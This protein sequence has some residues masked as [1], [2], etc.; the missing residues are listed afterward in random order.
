[1][2]TRSRLVLTLALVAL[3][4][5]FPS[6]PTQ[7]T[8]VETPRRGLTEV[9][10][11]NLGNTGFNTMAW[12]WVRGDKLYVGLGTW[13]TIPIF[14]GPPEGDL[15]PSETDNPAAPTKSGVK[16]LDATDPANPQLIKRIATVPGSQNNETRVLTEVST[17]SFTGDL[18][19]HSLEP[20]GGIGLISQFQDPSFQVPLAQ[21]GFQLYNV[22]DPANPVKLGTYNNGGIGTHNLYFVVR[23]D[24]GPTQR[25]FVLAVFN[26]VSDVPGGVRGELQIVEVTNPNSPTLIA[27][28]D[29]ATPQPDLP[30]RTRGTINYCVLHDVWPSDD[31]KTAYLSYWD[32]GTVL[33]DIANPATPQLIGQGLDQIYQTTGSYGVIDEGSTHA[34]MP[35][36]HWDGRRMI[37][38][39]DEDFYGGAGV[40][41]RV[42]SPANLA[43]FSV[44]DQWGGTAPVTGQTGNLVYASGGCTIADY[45]PLIAAGTIQ[46]NIAFLDEA[47]GI[48]QPGCDPYRFEQK[49]SAAEAA[50]AIGLV[51]VDTNDIP[52]GGAV[53]FSTIPAMEISHTAGVPI[54]DAVRGGTPV[55]ATLCRCGDNIDPWGFMRVIDVTDPDPANWRQVSTYEP[56]HVRDPIPDLEKDVFTAHHPMHGPDDR[57]YLSSYTTGVRV[58]EPTHEPG[59]FEEV[60]WFVP[61]PSDHPN[62]NDTDPHGALED[63]I[64]FWGSVPVI[65]PV[66]GQ[67]LIFNNDVNRGLYILAYETDLSVIKTD[68][69][70][71]APTGQTLTYTL[72]VTNEGPGLAAAVTVTDTLPASVTLLSADPSQGSCSGSALVSC[73]LGSIASGTSVTVS[74]RVRPTTPGIITNTATVSAITDTDLANNSDTEQTA[75]CR[76][77]SRRSSIP[78]R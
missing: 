70:D 28:W 52:S 7:A 62:D 53:E 10:F 71:P 22:T 40:G 37:L 72:T 18:L 50:G 55:S 4:G 51:Q 14:G 73:S 11:H 12:P 36:K 17:P 45:A 1:M 47:V 56:P 69:K 24:L 19:A 25:L 30:C 78:C 48:D 13:G 68:S 23:N 26:E 60:A 6:P 39:T 76:I 61:R 46:G 15:C 21:T 38:V 57:I 35:Y 44:G 63:N 43:G 32:A 8:H 9:G 64:G 66:T 33:L 2:R 16:I 58:L 65:H 20:C 59:H 77:T 54:L 75:V 74:I 5:L 31:G 29:L 49:T 27:T 41:P 42:N 3:A 34:T 67:L